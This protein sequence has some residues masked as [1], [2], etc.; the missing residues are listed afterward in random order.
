MAG[1]VI[2]RKTL[3]SQVDIIIS[4]KLRKPYI[5]LPSDTGG[6]LEF[7]NRFVHAWQVGEHDFFL[8]IYASCDWVKQLIGERV[9]YT[10]TSHGAGFA[11]DDSDDLQFR[12]W[13]AGMGRVEKNH[14]DS[15]GRGDLFEIKG[16]KDALQ[17]FINQLTKNFME[18]SSN[19][20]STILWA[21]Y[22]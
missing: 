5:M 20:T 4:G 16:H 14:V 15:C 7:L 12:C 11:D 18:W 2:A 3:E 19:Q 13:Y 6:R 8:D 17:P 22:V 9:M 1:Y 10:L 21:G